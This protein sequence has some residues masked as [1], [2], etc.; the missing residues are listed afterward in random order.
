MARAKKNTNTKS[1]KST[2]TAKTTKTTK[3]TKTAKTVKPKTAKAKA[4]KTASK[5]TVKPKTTKKAAAKAEVVEVADEDE[6]GRS[7]TGL[8]VQDG[9]VLEK[10]RYIARVP[11]AAGKKFKNKHPELAGTLFGVRETSKNVPRR[12]KKAHIYIE[13][14]LAEETYV[15][16]TYHELEYEADGKTKKVDE[17]GKNVYKLDKDGNKVPKMVE[18]ENGDLVPLVVRHRKR[19]PIYMYKPA[20]DDSEDAEANLKIFTL[21]SNHRVGVKAVVEDVP[22][23]EEEKAEV[24]VKPKAKTAKTKTT[25]TAKKAAPKKS[26][27][28]KGRKTANKTK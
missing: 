13:K 4:T 2:K 12:K 28:G 20:A 3:T 8:Y 23:V 25:K 22:E 26:A 27:K 10:G 19:N 7:F 5:K 9:V 1:A 16:T 14:P 15:E 21:L 11:K 18:D 6:S 17:N 24:V